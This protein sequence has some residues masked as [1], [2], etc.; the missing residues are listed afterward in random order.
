MTREVLVY[1]Y[2]AILKLAHPFMPFITEELWQAIPHRGEALIVAPFPEKGLPVDKGALRRFGVLQ[3]GVRR[4]RNARAEYNVEPARRV[5]AIVVCAD[6]EMLAALQ[7]EAGVMALLARLDQPQLQFAAEAPKMSADDAVQLVIG[8]G[9]EVFLP[10]AG[11]AGAENGLGGGT[12]PAS[13]VCPRSLAAEWTT[14]L[15]G[16]DALMFAES[17]CPAP[18]RADPVKEVARLSKQAAKI[19][20]ELVGASGRGAHP[21]L[22]SPFTTP[23]SHTRR[24]FG[25][26]LPSYQACARLS[27]RGSSY[28]SLYGFCSR[29]CGEAGVVRVHRQGAE[30]CRGQG[31]DTRFRRC[32]R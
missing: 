25:A 4:V 12:P 16:R 21:F 20:V 2:D 6:A 17:L 22:V 10:V 18:S 31:A 14:R 13:L 26:P 29:D 15:V 27:S 5:P 8:E 9:V 24:S 23:C 11:L 7:E 30:E 28:S 19:E 1:C 3:E 32:D